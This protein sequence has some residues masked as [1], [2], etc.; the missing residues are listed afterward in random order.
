MTKIMTDMYY[1][2]CSR[3]LP[4]LGCI[5]ALC[6]L[7]TLTDANILVECLDGLNNILIV[8]K[9]CMKKGL[10]NGV[11]IYVEMI[12]ECGGLNKIAS[13]QCNDNYKV[14]SRSLNILVEYFQ[15]YLEEDEENH[16]NSVDGTMREDLEV[17]EK[18][19]HNSVD[20]TM[21][22]DPDGMIST[23]CSFHILTF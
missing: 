18:N 6:D 9:A 12:E 8:G 17:D 11:N 22:E 21:K 16:H 23:V 1:G 4:C 5:E 10:Y 13:L 14:Y 2:H 7:L 19:L 3:L 15:D 20:K